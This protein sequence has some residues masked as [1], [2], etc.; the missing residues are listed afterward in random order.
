MKL[1]LKDTKPFVK[2]MM[3]IAITM[4]MTSVAAFTQMAMKS[5]NLLLIQAI[6]T[7]IVF[8]F[9]VVFYNLFFEKNEIYKQT[10]SSKGKWWY[11]IVGAVVIIASTPF[12]DILAQW[13]NTWHFHGEE[14][15][16]RLTEVSEQLTKQM[17]QGQSV[18]SLLWASITIAL[19]PAVFEEWFFRG[20]LQK[21]FIS[22]TKNAY[23]GILITSIIFSLFHFD[24]FNFIPRVVLGMILGLLF[25]YS[26]CIYINMTAHFINNFI[27]VLGYW[28]CNRGVIKN[29]FSSF[30]NYNSIFL[31]ICSIIILS[32]WIFYSEKKKQRVINS[33]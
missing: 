13:N 32:F 3:M 12:V 11:F 25:Y 14:I 21:L 7:I 4:V 27:V 5:C 24:V 10:F 16:R 22:W 33:K 20:T 30:D 23:I 9:S 2:F 6:T 1:F 19:F 28:L 26:K 15:F 31:V 8:G 18:S 17:V 29:D